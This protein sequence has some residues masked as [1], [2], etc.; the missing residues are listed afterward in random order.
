MTYPTGELSR[1]VS[2][3][4]LVFANW[5]LTSLL[6]DI[7]TDS[8]PVR[9]ACALYIVAVSCA[10]NAFSLRRSW[11]F[12]GAADAPPETLLSLFS[13]ICNLS[14]A[15]GALFAATRY[16]SLSKDDPFFEHSFLRAQ[17][18][19]FYEMSL[20]Q[21][22]VGWTSTVPTT[23]LEKIVAWL[24]TFVGGVLCTNMFLLS[25]VLSRRGYW[26]NST[27]STEATAANLSGA[28]LPL[29]L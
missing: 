18:E 17:F 25:V 22:G 6:V 3:F 13:E 7:L 12:L 19:S 10:A 23:V 11:K 27:H 15:W 24:A 21:A 9:Q 28:F 20:V 8:T 1:D 2:L 14:Q 16:L 26:Q 4:L 29:K 5:T